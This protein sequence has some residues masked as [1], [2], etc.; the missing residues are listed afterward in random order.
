M[1]KIWA[2]KSMKCRKHGLR[3]IL[4]AYK[5][6]IDFI[7][8]WWYYNYSG[9]IACIYPDLT[10]ILVARYGLGLFRNHTWLKREMYLSDF[11]S[12]ALLLAQIDHKDNRLDFRIVPYANGSDTKRRMA[13]S[14]KDLQFK[15][16]MNVG[17]T[18]RSGNGEKIVGALPPPIG[19]SYGIVE[20][21]K[22]C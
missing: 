16:P 11:F 5:V 18:S 7:T 15:S 22:A 6:Y 2:I 14:M 20:W 10:Q 19:D 1:I 8:I 12:D 17:K 9:S 3:W 4:A 13:R 21:W